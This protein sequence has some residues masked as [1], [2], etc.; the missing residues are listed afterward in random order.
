MLIIIDFESDKPIYIQLEEQIIQGIAKGE[1]QDGE[2][3][4]SVR[5]MASDIGINLHTVNKA[6]NLLKSD[7]YISMDRR[8]G[9][10]VNPIEKFPSEE[11][12]EELK[13]E[14]A[15]NIA[16]AYCKGITEDEY[17]KICKEIFSHYN[18]ED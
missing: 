7:G 12:I 1:L 3:L 17:L 15:S 10:I 16:A 4:P 8:K 6:Y 11:Y 14:L 9:A 18:K 13:G 2:N 5:Q